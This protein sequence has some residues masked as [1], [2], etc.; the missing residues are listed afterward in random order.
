M[1]SDRA[2]GTGDAFN[3]DVMITG[4]KLIDF[5]KRKLRKAL[6]VGGAEVR[7]QARRLVSRRAIS[8]P[9]E[10]PGKDSGALA[11]SIKIYKRGSRGGYVKVG[12]TKTAEMSAFYPAFLF[13]GSSKNNL[14]PRKN[15]MT[16]ALDDKRT[17]VRQQILT[18]MVG[19]LVPR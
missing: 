4:H 12:P 6:L 7:K 8:Q 14:Q 15:Y 19:A 5:D 18:S 9:G 1:D 17:F 16:D 2:T 13:Y 10:Y 3:L 11:R